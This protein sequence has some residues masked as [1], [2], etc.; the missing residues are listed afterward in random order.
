MLYLFSLLDLHAGSS[1]LTEDESRR[2]ADFYGKNEIQVRRH[3]DRYRSG[4]FLIDTG[5]APS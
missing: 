3:L 4:A 1:G 5:Q 2:R